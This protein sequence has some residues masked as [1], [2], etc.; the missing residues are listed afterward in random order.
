M[1][2]HDPNAVSLQAGERGAL[3]WH[4]TQAGTVD[5]ACTL[6]GHLEAGMV[7]RNVVTR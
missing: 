6:P 1:A 7:G 5:F 2:H 3:V 4:F